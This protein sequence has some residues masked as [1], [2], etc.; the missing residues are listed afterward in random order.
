MEKLLLH[1]M[2]ELHLQGIKPPWDAIVKRLCDGSTGQAAIQ[3]L[4][5]LRDILVAE[6][7][8][9]PPQMGKGNK[10]DPTIRGYIRD[11]DSR[12]PTDVKVL[13][14]GEFHED[15]K[16]NLVIPG[17]VRGSGNYKKIQ[18]YELSSSTTVEKLAKPADGSRRSR[19]PAEIIEAKKAKEVDETKIKV[20]RKS[21]RILHK[22]ARTKKPRV[23][24]STSSVTTADPADMDSDD[25]YNPNV[26]E[27]KGSARKLAKRSKRS[28]RYVSS[29]DEDDLEE[30]DNIFFSDPARYR[31]S[32]QHGPVHGQ[33]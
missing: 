1:L 10:I 29:D 6:G 19:L 14:W 28:N 7:H 5:K 8:M 16:E 32:W 4:H 27:G 12:I 3:H 20:G 24:S 18:N 11:M 13:R 23:C 9:V 2:Y 33:P 17:V 26:K 30:E 15:R 31:N 22:V 25:E 21:K